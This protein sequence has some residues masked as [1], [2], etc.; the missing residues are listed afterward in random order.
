MRASRL[1][2]LCEVL[3]AVLTVAFALSLSLQRSERE[4][5]ALL[6]LGVQSAV[7]FV[8]AAGLYQGKRWGWL[9][10]TGLL[11]LTIAPLVIT[12]LL[13]WRAGL[14]VG[15][16]VPTASLTLLAVAWLAQFV[17]AL[18]FLGARGWRPSTPGTA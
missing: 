10:A 4:S 12:I 14:A 3:F 18:C 5:G 13:A 8:A 9:L 2:A 11:A 15:L 16:A 7:G 17:V 1:A 6:M